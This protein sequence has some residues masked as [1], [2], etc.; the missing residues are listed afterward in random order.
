VIS[1]YAG[2]LGKRRDLP[3]ELRPDVEQIAR[4]AQRG[5]ELTRQLLLFARREQLRPQRF[6]LS[7]TL[8]ELGALMTRPL[9]PRI[10]LVVDSEPGIVIDADRGQIEQM[11]LNLLINARD[12]LPDGGHITLRARLEAGDGTGE[13]G[14]PGQVVLEVADDGIG[15]PAEVRAHVFEPFFTTKPRSEASGLGLATVQG[16]VEQAGGTIAITSAPGAGT[17]VSVR[18]P[19]C[20]DGPEQRP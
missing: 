13:G 5:A 18:L 12:A 9:R 16:I 7:R 6:D 17:T 15:M 2:F 4:A 14:G 8:D 11:V 3:D 20:D 19:A 10:E 1:N